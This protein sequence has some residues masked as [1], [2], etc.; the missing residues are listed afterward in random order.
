M[1]AQNWLWVKQS[2][3]AGAANADPFAIATDSGGN[4]AMTGVFN[5]SVSF[6]SHGIG[7][8]AA[9]L[10]YFV[11]RYDY[12][13]NPL[14]ASAASM[15]FGKFGMGVSWGWGVSSDNAGNTYTTGYYTSPATFGAFTLN[16][17]GP[18]N[19][20][21]V[22]YDPLGN[23]LW[24]KAPGCGISGYN[25]GNAVVTDPAGNIYMTGD[26][27]DSAFFGATTLVSQAG[28]DIFLA[29]YSAAGNPI[30]AKCAAMN[31]KNNTGAGNSVAFDNAGHIYITGSYT[32]ST[33]FGTY[34]LTG[35]SK[36]NNNV[37]VTKYDTAGIN[38]IWATSATL[39]SSA[40]SGVANS[41]SADGA[42]NVYITGYYTEIL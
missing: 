8:G 33:T 21:L 2:T 18:A 6:G 17:S 15:G 13:G 9:T 3:D 39:P 7:A 12:N 20:F 29:K 34:T 28:N 32:D 27:V 22:K 10:D 38:V 24:A 5:G 36:K 40:C 35:G 41:I 31:Y 42:K 1:H 19:A 16:Y 11:V 25:Q 4:A 26:F 37:F 14:W 30:W 23:V